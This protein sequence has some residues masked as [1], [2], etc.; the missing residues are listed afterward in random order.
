VSANA[1]FAI[2]NKGVLAF[3]RM[4]T[5]SVLLGLVLVS[6]AVAQDRQPVPSGVIYGVVMTSNGEPARGLSL[7]AMPLGVALDTALPH[8][9]TN[10]QGE[11]RFE[12]LPW[13]GK[14]TVYADDEEAGYSSYSTGTAANGHPPGVEVTPESPKAE[15]NLSLPPMAGFIQIRLAN[16][17]T[18]TAIPAMRIAIAPMEKPDAPLFTDPRVFTMSCYSD[19]AILVPPNE[20]LLLHVKSDGFR[21]WDESVGKGKPI[22]LPSGAVLTLNVQLDPTE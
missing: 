17:K 7:A 10:D 6:V 9:K 12:K 4:K 8:T 1:L 22:N 19:H 18:G 14:Y 15:L 2:I 20:N 13:W 3:R 11:Y 16:R 21:E 5:Q